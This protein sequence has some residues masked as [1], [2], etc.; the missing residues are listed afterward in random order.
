MPS[1]PALPA[2]LRR[3]DIF[4]KVVDHFGDAG[5][6]W[7]LARQLARE[8]DLEVTL[9]IDQPSAL[10][11]MAPGLDPNRTM[12]WLAGVTVRCRHTCRASTAPAAVVIDTFGGGLPDD[13]VHAMAALR[14]PPRWFVLEYL[15]AEA[16]VE[17]AHG[18]PS[19]H[20]SMGLERTFWFPG[21][22]AA[23][24][25]LLREH[26][27]L[28]RRD[29]F[30]GDALAQAT[31]WETLQLGAPPPSA[32]RVSLFCYPKAPVGMLLDQ[33]VC[34]ARQVVCMV[35]AGTAET[36]IT[37]WLGGARWAPGTPVHRGQLTLHAIP[38]L[39]QDRYDE[40]LWAC[41]LNFVRGED[42]F[43]R[44]QWA[45]KPLVWQ[46]YPQRDSA[47]QV[48][49][50][51]FMDRYLGPPGGATGRAS[52]LTKP[53]RAGV[54][55]TKPDPQDN[56]FVAIRG[57]WQA[58]NEVDAASPVAEAWERWRQVEPAIGAHAK[59]WTNALVGVPQL[60]AG[61]VAAVMSKV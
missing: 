32:L 11:A 16:W 59:S 37:A 26:D 55:G 38:F 14:T 40:L 35:P 29:A 3:W 18:R 51:A 19:P 6:A 60:G 52:D 25:G 42:S 48:K 56:A 27:L 2:P 15:T 45:G 53:S 30:L 23:T 10:A 1:L 46:A 4:C 47:H 9:W 58:W 17:G 34:G 31:L 57:L 33:W 22:T 20:P 13:Y 5:V 24:G 49:L 8:H 12:Q 54:P 61:L 43:V 36:A 21:F 44:A 50:A 41:N 28:L 7:R 39:A